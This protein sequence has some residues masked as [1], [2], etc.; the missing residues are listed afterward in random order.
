MKVERSLLGR[1][2][3]GQ[4]VVVILFCVLATGNL[5]W[6]F[7]KHG[8]GE[9]DQQF[10][11]GVKTFL[12]VLEAEK[13]DPAELR[14]ALA[15]LDRASQ[16]AV[17]EGLAGKT[18]VHDEI[19]TIVRATDRGGNELYATSSPAT[20]ALQ[21]LP[22]GFSQFESSGRVWRALT[23]QNDDASLTIQLA[24]T[25]NTAACELLTTI[26]KF[27]FWPL[28]WFLP[29][30]AIMTWLVAK[31]GL[32]PL[33]TL[34]ELIARRSPSDLKP[35]ENIK[36]YCETTP[37]ID[38]INT[39]LRK[40]DTTL[41][42]E[43]NFLAD[44]AHELRTPLAVLQAQVHVLRH[45]TSEPEKNAASEELNVGIARAASLI[46]KLLLTARVSVD[47]FVPRFEVTDLTAFVQER[48]ATLS[49]LAEAKH[50]EMELNA[51]PHCFAKVD[52]ETLGSAIDNVID[53]AIRY[54]PTHGKIAIAIESLSG[55][56]VRLSIADNGAGIPVE[57]RDRVFERFY[58]V[59]GNEQPGSGL[60]LAIVKR[61]VALHGGAVSLSTGLGER[62]LA[63]DLTVPIG[64]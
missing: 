22:V 46:R 51:P 53:N 42:R 11:M 25:N 37:L 15:L 44:A 16:S 39:L 47:D 13:N 60:G 41:T 12:R 32:S 2:I 20:S 18:S 49:P 21:L 48:V 36:S 38:E 57:A 8:E 26:T 7:F 45:A 4:L 58:R 5:L 29:F 17:A 28:V 30:A 34:S 6:Q 43:R 27:I 63:V 35:I 24:Q 14:K 52:R 56:R 50:I 31:R 40:L 10:V 59:P 54:T 3:V 1:I 23:M 19:Q 33:H 64:A 61:V 9:L 62:G 55:D